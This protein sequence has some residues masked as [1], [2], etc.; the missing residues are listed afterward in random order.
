MR[1][2]TPHRKDILA[3][4]ITV[5]TPIV[6]RLWLKTGEVNGTEEEE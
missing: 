5:L 4:E 2:A 3:T 1:L 6:V